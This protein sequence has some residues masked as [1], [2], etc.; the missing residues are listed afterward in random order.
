MLKISPRFITISLILLF[1]LPIAFQHFVY[2]LVEDHSDAAG[3]SESF[4][5]GRRALRQ[6]I[7]SRMTLFT[8]LERVDYDLHLRSIAKGKIS[9]HVAVVEIGER[10]LKDLGQFPFTR[11]IYRQL[12]ERLEKAGAKV[13]A[14]DAAFPEHDARIDMLTQLRSLRHEIEQTEGFDSRAVKQI[15]SRIFE[16]DADEDFATA[17]HATKLPVVLGFTLTDAHEDVAVTD[18]IKSLLFGYGMYRKSFM[19]PSVLNSYSGR[20]PVLS[21]AEIMR[22]LNKASSVG[23]INPEIDSDSII[24][25][26]PAVLEYEGRIFGSLALRA[27]AAYYGE[28]PI[29]DG[30]G[31][32]TVR[33][34]T[35]DPSGDTVPGQLHFPLYVDGTFRLR[36]YGSDRTFPYIEFSDIVKDRL[37]PAQLSEQVGG[38]I[39]FV[40]ATAQGLKDLRATPLSAAYPG[41][42][43]H[44]TMASNVLEG[45]FL[46]KDQR[47]FLFGYLFV[48]CFSL[49]VS[50]AVYRFHPL[51]SFLVTVASVVGTQ[52]LAQFACFNNGVI[53]PSI[54]PSVS[55]LSV[56]FTGVLYRYFTEEREKKVVRA[57]FS[58]YV[59]G[60][61][62]E[63][64][65][66]DQTKLR[67]GGQK[68]ELTLMFVDLVEFTKLS[69][70]MDASFVTQLL[71]EYFTR[72]TNILLRN[73]GTLDK[74]MGDGLMC[75]WGAP[76]EIPDHAR[77]ACLT[78]IEMRSELARINHEWKLKH[79]ITIESRIGVHTGVV[80]VGNMGSDQVF[81]YT[82]MGDNVNLGSRLEGVNT[83]YGTSVLVSA[84]TAGAAGNGFLF[85]PLDRVQVKGKEDSVDI[86]ELVSQKE[87]RE[88]EWVHAFRTGLSHYQAGEWDDAE[89]AFGACLSLKPGDGPSQ[90]FIDRIRDFRL[91]EPEEWKGV[92]RLSSK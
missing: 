19:D 14:F 37:S 73:K 20:M 41:V 40:G 83:V 68:K 81:S 62:V 91:V 11:T 76:L 1:S 8:W 53:A 34:V 25:S 75:F 58:R 64:I 12:I 39:I 29:I 17:L 90:V 67:L 86:L 48:I 6:S 9:P 80:A 87:E 84:A 4:M 88:P 55:C 27:I 7:E 2:V 43:A 45:T 57:A 47:F 92:W 79:G 13:V 82:V 85:R 59:S 66:K 30:E 52:L 33:G 32:L 28:E 50:W 21:I 23:H 42:E 18:E 74:Y 63:E 31:A 61:V 89:S 44:A 22:S 51:A 77:L 24:R 71:N 10:S 65:L 70:H 26:I 46:L 54:L 69:E 38:K 5:A 60:A 78:A 15:D 56:F 35:R 16:I 49:L 72:M 36:Y 3:A